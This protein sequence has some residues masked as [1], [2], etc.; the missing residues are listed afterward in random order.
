[1]GTKRG[2]SDGMLATLLA[3][4][5]VDIIDSPTLFVTLLCFLSLLP[6][7][8]NRVATIFIF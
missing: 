8:L 6:L 4:C 1:M 2:P 5:R 3:F 7:M